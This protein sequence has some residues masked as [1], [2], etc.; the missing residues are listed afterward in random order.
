MIMPAIEIIT[1]EIGTSHGYIIHEYTGNRLNGFNSI[2]DWIAQKGMVGICV[3]DVSNTILV[4]NNGQ[5]SWKAFE[6]QV[7][8]DFILHVFEIT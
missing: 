2:G 3:K 1:K 4:C 7:G 6:E 5:K 8:N